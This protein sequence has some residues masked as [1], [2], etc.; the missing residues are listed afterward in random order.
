MNGGGKA[1]SNM[2]ESTG[3]IHG[4]VIVTRGQSAHNNGTNLGNRRSSMGRRS[5]KDASSG[6]HNTASATNNVHFDPNAKAY[7]TSDFGT[8]GMPINAKG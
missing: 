8:A 3:H 2:N 6:L 7:S 1:Q 5:M 4:T